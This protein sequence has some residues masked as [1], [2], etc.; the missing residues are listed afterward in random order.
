MVWSSETASAILAVGAEGS[1]VGNCQQFYNT[2]IPIRMFNVLTGLKVVPGSIPNV[3][4]DVIKLT[5]EKVE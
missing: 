1:D 2:N 3:L 5:V 4:Y